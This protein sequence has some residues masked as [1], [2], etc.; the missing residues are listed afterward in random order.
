M[1]RDGRGEEKVYGK[2][3]YVLFAVWLVL[4]TAALAV[5][6]CYPGCF[7]LLGAG[8]AVGLLGLVA[9]D[10]LFLLI[11][12][13]ESVYWIS[14]VTYEEAASAGSRAR[15]QFALRHLVIF[16]AMTVLFLLYCFWLPRYQ[17]TTST[18]DS[19]AAGVMVCTGALAS[20][21]VRFS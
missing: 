14:P 6:S 5:Y 13:T 2:K 1:D 12:L 17:Y 16:L 19:I 18:W 21:K 9:L 10:L 7:T 3:S 4:Y 15:K 8:K 11:Y 20:G